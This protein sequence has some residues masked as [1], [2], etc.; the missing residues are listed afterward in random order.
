MRGNVLFVEDEEAL[1][2]TVGDR[3]RNEGYRVDF[4][5]NGAEGFEK[6]TQLPFDLI[7]LDIML[8]KRSGFDVCQGIREA[9]LITPI[10]MLTA[11]GQTSDKVNGLKIGADDYVT[12]PFNMLELM[13]RVEALMRRAPIRPAAQ[14]G[15]LDFGPVR[16]DLVG[17][18]ATRDG[19]PVNLSA[20]EFQLLR[21][22]VEH[23][24]ATL[25]R[26]ELLK[27]VW[28]YNADMYTRTVDV[29]VASLRQKLED[30]PKQPKYILTVQGLGYKFKA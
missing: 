24:G 14:T 29:H 23:R 5:A 8:P 25:S 15:A 3:L 28:G 18:E 11:R 21:Y 17:T 7:I 10:L 13:A 16:V 4:A 26:E 19:K 22:F 12:K 6:A 2:M 27:Q 20:R 1:R 30:D 9:G